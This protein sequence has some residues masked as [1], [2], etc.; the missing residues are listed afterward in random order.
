M[1][2]HLASIFGT[3]K[4]RVNCPFYFKI[5]ACR[6]GDRCSRLHTKPSIS[7]T[8]LLSNMYQRPDMI[9]PGVD[10][11][12]QPLDPSKIQ[13][14]FEDFYEDLFE[15]LGKYGE[16]ESLNICDNLADHMVGNVYAQFREEEHAAAALQNLSGRFYAGRPIIVDFSPVTDFRE[17]TCRQ[18]E[19]NVC[20]RGGYCN[21]MHLKK[22]SKELRRQ[23]FGR[24]RRSRSRSR[25]PQRNRN[26][27][28][29]PQGG[30]RGS[31]RRGGG[32]SDHRSHD[33]RGRRPRSRSPGRRGAGRSRSPGGKRNRSPVR[34]GS[35]ERRAKI[36]QWNREKEQSK[37]GPKTASS[38]ENNDGINDDGAPQNGDHYYEPHQ[39][40][41]PQQ[42]DGG[43]D[44]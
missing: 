9:T 36:E 27:D 24:R 31:G 39:E 10:P 34:E 7:P 30:G 23:L 40:K 13:D 20:N 18:Y 8:L 38:N 43:Y 22:I 19:E 17:A 5:G 44:Y 4:D 2:E 11:Q 12:G 21:F 15:E 29:R 35:A 42:D 3:E 28:E 6:H 1:A 25:S 41:Q 16:I 32:Y 37:T 33:S 14:H 26:Y